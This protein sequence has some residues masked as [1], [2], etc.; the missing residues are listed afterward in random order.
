MGAGLAA[1]YGTV[2]AA[3]KA[4]G[5]V[6]R[7]DASGYG[8]GATLSWLGHGG[9]RLL[10]GFRGN[11]QE[12]CFGPNGPCARVTARLRP[13]GGTLPAPGRGGSATA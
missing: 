4:A 6:G 2:D 7:Q 10:L 1:Q 3:A 9:F 5:G 11:H 13:C 8:I 12:R